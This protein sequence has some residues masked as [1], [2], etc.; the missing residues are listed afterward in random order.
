MPFIPEPRAAGRQKF[1]SRP[2]C[3]EISHFTSQERWLKNKKGRAYHTGP[4]A[5][6]RMQDWR[7]EHPHYWRRSASVAATVNGGPRDLPTVLGEF[8]GK[9]S[10]DA[11]Q[12][13]W[14]PQVVAFVGLITWLRG[15]ALQDTIAADIDEIMVA[16]NDLLLAMGASA[17]KRKPQTFSNEP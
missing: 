7:K 11:L 4:V 17:P 10:C 9:D 5:V 14:S 6:S 8:F 1:C 15:D 13:S 12:D 2:A 3:R 16:G